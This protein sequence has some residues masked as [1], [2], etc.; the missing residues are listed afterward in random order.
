MAVLKT[1]VKVDAA[2]WSKEWDRWVTISKI[3]VPLKIGTAM[4]AELAG[5]CVCAHGNPRSGFQHKL[6]CGEYQSVCQQNSQQTM[7]SQSVN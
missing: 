4:A 3:S 1:M 2:W 7:M 5:V 6:V